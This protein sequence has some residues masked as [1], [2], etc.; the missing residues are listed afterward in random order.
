MN[1]IA[2]LLLPLA[3]A[4]LS[5]Q[6]APSQKSAPQPA[7]PP[8]PS[9]IADAAPA[10]AWAEIAPDDLLVMTLRGGRQVVMQL[11]PRFAPVHTANIR[12][13]ALAHWWDRTAVY[14][15]QDNYVAQWGDPPPDPDSEGTKTL[16][17]NV[18]RAIPA[19]YEVAADAIPFRPLGGGDAYAETG[20]SEGWPVA[21]KD[22]QAWLTHC[23]AM[24]GAGR[25]YA[26]D[27]G[28]GAELY[29]VIGHAPRHLDRNIAL[30]GRVVEG[31]EALSSLP[32][33]TGPLS[34]YTDP[35]Q[36]TP[37]VSIRLASDMPAEARP[38][39]QY[40]K[41]ESAAFAAYATARQNREPPFFEKP[42]GGADICNV[43]VPL[44]RIKAG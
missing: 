26:P 16:P 5:A 22:G 18:T 31:I 41:T 33:G 12:A 27:T 14:R 4:L 19:E 32:R 30:I 42:A 29:A 9:Q 20:H 8:S 25:G 23:Y 35:A 3:A 34:F 13:L 28:S 36:F 6:S 40:L 7:P 17:G 15:V 38:R 1:R 21:R 2:P 24:V 10:D 37:I 44:R 11:A 43:P 39:F